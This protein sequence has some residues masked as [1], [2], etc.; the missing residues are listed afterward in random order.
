MY[1]KL[2]TAGITGLAVLN[3]PFYSTDN[4]ELLKQ[5]IMDKMYELRCR[6]RRRMWLLLNLT[7][8]AF[9]ISGTFCLILFLFS[10]AFPVSAGLH[11]FYY[12]GNGG[13]T[14]YPGFILSRDENGQFLLKPE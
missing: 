3:E 4:N 14:A 1:S 7:G 13:V 5:V 8:R 2:I 9:E 10:T 12:A 6:K 11:V